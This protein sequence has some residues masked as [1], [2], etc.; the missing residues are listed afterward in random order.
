MLKKIRITFL[1]GILIVVSGQTISQQVRTSAWNETLKVTIYP[2]NGDGELV[3]ERYL[4]KLDASRFKE[5]ESFMQAQAKE[6]G[7]DGKLLDISVAP[8]LKT[9]PPMPPEGQ[10]ILSSVLYSLRLRAWGLLHQNSDYSSDIRLFVVYYD[11]EESME[12]PRSLALRKGM[13][14]LVNVFADESMEGMNNFV[15]NHEMLHTLGATDKY[16][17]D[18]NHPYFPEGYARPFQVERHQQ[19]KAEI[20]GGRIPIGPRNAIMP[21]SLDQAM[22]GSYTALELSWFN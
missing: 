10:G 6:Y 1:L 21:E 4:R 3:T 19:V 20:M 13:I 7:I 2:I 17:L 12:I 16:H 18:T 8:L 5:I 11:P 9:M 22:I 14:G 15:I